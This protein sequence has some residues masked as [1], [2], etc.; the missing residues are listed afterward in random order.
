MIMDH[1]DMELPVQVSLPTRLEQAMQGIPQ[2]H[3]PVHHYLAGGIYAR[4]MTLSSGVTVTGAVHKSEHLC[5][6]SQG[7]LLVYGD[8][9]VREMRAPFTFVSKPG[10]QRVGFALETTVWTTY[11]LVGDERDL[12]KIML[13]V[14]GQTNAELGG[15]PLNPQHL[16]QKELEEDRL[17]Y[18]KFLAEYGLDQVRVHLLSHREEDRVP[19]PEPAPPVVPAPSPI[20]G[21]GLFATHRILQGARLGLARVNGRRTPFGYALNHSVRPNVI[22]KPLPNGDIEIWT[23]RQI[24]PGEELTNDYRQAMSANGSGVMPLERITS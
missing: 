17:D 1:H 21:Q 4:E 11:H 6:I 19:F 9:M 16:R 8:G 20:E 2:A 23:L 7:K 18:Q 3:C 15:G 13:E 12:D 22:G 14:C 5:T 24:E 10:A